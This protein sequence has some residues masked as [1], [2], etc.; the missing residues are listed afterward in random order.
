M[1]K[2]RIGNFLSRQFLSLNNKLI[3]ENLI[4]YKILEDI[5]L[6]EKRNKVT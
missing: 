5:L 1:Y 3:N 2:T 4:D 6:F